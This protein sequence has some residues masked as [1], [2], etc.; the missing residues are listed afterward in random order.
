LMEVIER[1]FILVSSGGRSKRRFIDCRPLV[2][3]RAVGS[4]G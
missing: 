3:V 1:T 2:P 4:F